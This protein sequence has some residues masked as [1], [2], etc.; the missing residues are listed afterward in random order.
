MEKLFVIPV[1]G[2]SVFF[3][4]YILVLPIWSVMQLKLSLK[5][6]VGVCAVFLTGGL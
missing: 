1:A 2:F 5:R 4:L 3:D 6:A